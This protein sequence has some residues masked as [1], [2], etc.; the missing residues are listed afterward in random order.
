MVQHK[1]NPS[2]LALVALA[3]SLLATA[4]IFVSFIHV[5]LVEVTGHGIGSTLWR[6]S[7]RCLGYMGPILI[8]L[9][10]TFWA[11]RRLRR[12]IHDELWTEAEL[13]RVRT[14]VQKPFW[15]WFSFG[16]IAV[17]LFL[18]VFRQGFNL[19]FFIGMLIYPSQVAMRIRQLVTPAEA[20]KILL[21]EW[22]SS[23]PIHS[24]HWGEVRQDGDTSIA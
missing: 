19:G 9:P 4:T 20:P 1:P 6:N 10:P 12:G 13:D 11:E 2:R 15:R 5:P 16:L 22:Q 23:K 21:R 24:E 7:L 18:F 3:G 17:C 8:G 14:L